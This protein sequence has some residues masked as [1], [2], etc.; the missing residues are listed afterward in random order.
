[1]MT[2]PRS[3]AVANSSRT[4]S[5]GSSNRLAPAS[6]LSQSAPINASTT[7][8]VITARVIRST[9]WSPTTMASTSIKTRNLPENPRS[10]FGLSRSEIR[11]AIPNAPEVGLA[12][13]KCGSARRPSDDAGSTATLAA[14]CAALDPDPSEGPRRLDA[15]AQRSV[16]GRCS[17]HGMLACRSMVDWTAPRMVACWMSCNPAHTA[18]AAG[19]RRAR[20]NEMIVPKPLSWRCTAS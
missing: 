20:R 3:N 15:H 5:F 4:K 16:G 7:S 1:M 17:W 10:T 11:L 12:P 2:I 6:P 13:L 19:R 14:R 18:S 8:G 9:K